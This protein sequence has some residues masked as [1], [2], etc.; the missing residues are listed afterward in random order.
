MIPRV[1]KVLGSE[2][3]ADLMTKHLDKTTMDG[4]MA[5]LPFE[6]SNGDM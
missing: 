5:R 6:E 1:D 4:L 3:I 2:N